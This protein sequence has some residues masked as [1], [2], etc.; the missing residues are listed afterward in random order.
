M[1]SWS[2]DLHS[3]SGSSFFFVER[4][5]AGKCTKGF[6]SDFDSHLGLISLEWLDQA[7][8]SKITWEKDER[9]CS[10]DRYV[11][12]KEQSGKL[13]ESFAFEVLYE[14]WGN[15]YA[16]SL[17]LS[18]LQGSVRQGMAVASSATYSFFFENIQ[19]RKQLPFDKKSLSKITFSCHVFI[20]NN[21]FM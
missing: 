2:F 5:G 11:T 17:T 9:W 19:K 15:L 20:K 6:F 10:S 21:D 12:T 7:W 1:F 16:S 4:T 14:L 13:G 3:K 8:A 18:T